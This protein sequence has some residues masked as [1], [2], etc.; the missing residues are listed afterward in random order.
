MSRQL[1][2][3]LALSLCALACRGPA[4]HCAAGPILISESQ[5]LPAPAPFK[6]GVASAEF[7]PDK[8][9]PLGGYGGGTRRE[10]FPVMFGVG[11]FG[12][13]SLQLS[14]HLMDDEQHNH[15]LAESEG[16]HDPLRARAFVIVP[17]GDSPI[18]FCRMDLV[19]MT[20]ALRDRVLELTKSLGVRAE[21]LS[22]CANHTHS[23]V[24][25][26]SADLFPKLIAMDNYRPEIFEALAQSAARAIR[27]ALMSARPASLSVARAEDLKGP[28]A[29]ARNRRARKFDAIKREDK[30]PEILALVARLHSR[31]AKRSKQDRPVLGVLVNYSVHPTVLGPQ[32]VYFSADLAGALEYELEKSL[33][34]KLGRAVPVLFFNGAQGDIGP[35]RTNLKHR[36][37]LMA[38]HEIGQRF[39]KCCLPAL[40]EDRSQ[41][42]LAMISAQS[43][44]SF[45]S[46]IGIIAPG[47]RKDFFEGAQ[48]PWSWLTMPLTLPINLPFVVLGA[49]EIRALL[50]WNMRFGVVAN[51]DF[52]AETTRFP[53]GAWRLSLG[54]EDIMVL[55]IPGEATHDLGLELKAYARTLGVKRVFIMGLCNDAMSYITSEREY[56]RGGYEGGATLFGPQTGPHLLAVLKACMKDLM[57]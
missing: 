39:V 45:G 49:P 12:R 10:S 19:I 8:G 40:L 46:P 17:K 3:I 11:V 4:L 14:Q 21:R 13:W 35:G 55:Q 53:V 6:V 29:V 16:S 20:R 1:L 18:V 24:G 33:K 30:D 42:Q 23:G 43:N 9:Y 51:L 26:F 36:G 22:L 52:Y 41:S 2:S 34:A 31:R 56:D 37:G 50:T 28:E 27:E 57:K 15:Y 25:A 38:A 7:T 5:S 32:N 48:S 44:P 54:A 47:S